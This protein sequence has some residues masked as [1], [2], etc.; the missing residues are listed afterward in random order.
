M[1]EAVPME[2]PLSDGGKEVGVGWEMETRQA[3]LGGDGCPV[4]QKGQGYYDLK[5]D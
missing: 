3:I 5:M 1:S 2:Q 4:I